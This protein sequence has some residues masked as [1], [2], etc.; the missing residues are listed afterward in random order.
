MDACQRRGLELESLGSDMVSLTTG[1]ASVPDVRNATSL[2]TNKSRSCVTA[3]VLMPKQTHLP[4][5]D[6]QDLT[7]SL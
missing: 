2:A 4:S 7:K 5:D 1:A 3:A 6:R